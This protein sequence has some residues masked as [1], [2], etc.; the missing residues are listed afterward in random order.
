MPRFV[1]MQV[2]QVGGSIGKGGK[3]GGKDEERLNVDV[4]LEA[5]HSVLYD[6][7]IVLDGEPAVSAWSEASTAL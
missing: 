5:L 2:C 6:A 7:V 3:T 4:S 1:G